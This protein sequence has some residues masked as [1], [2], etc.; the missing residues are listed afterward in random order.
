MKH[1]AMISLE[2]APDT[3]ARPVA[4]VEMQDN[5]PARGIGA[6]ITLARQNITDRDTMP[7]RHLFNKY[8]REKRLRHSAPFLHAF[9][10][11]ELAP[12]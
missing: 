11:D 5:I 9:T 2:Q 6:R 7:E 4:L 10:S 12:T 3:L 1:G 8:G